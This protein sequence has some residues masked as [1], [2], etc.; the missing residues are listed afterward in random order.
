MSV[1]NIS[2]E[3]ILSM[4]PEPFRDI[5]YLTE[6]L[7]SLLIVLATFV[8]SGIVHNFIFAHLKKLE[9]SDDL[10]RKIAAVSKY[11]VYLLG[12]LFVLWVW[13]IDAIQLFVGLGAFSIAISFA[14][15]NTIENL[16]SGIIILTDK[17]FKV[18]DIIE[19]GGN[20]G[21]VKKITVRYT[22]IET[23]DGVEIFI[24]SKSFLQSSFKNFSSK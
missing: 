22:I 1:E 23:N 13:G 4:L 10:E 3:A 9:L 24:P 19:V 16:V 14:L 15:K 18:G 17:P 7:L 12:L 6:V 11:G 21:E 5:P 20:K 8:F 2:Q